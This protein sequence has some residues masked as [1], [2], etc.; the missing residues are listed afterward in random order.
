GCGDAENAAWKLAH[1]LHG[2]APES[3]LDSYHAERH[4]AAAANLRV[5]AATMRFLVP[6]TAAD[7]AHRLRVLRAAAGD[8]AARAEIDS[9]RLSVPYRYHDSPLTTPAPGAA[10]LPADLA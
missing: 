3:L 8:P 9:G 7:R 4:A 10:P 6:R 1:V 5:T 2:W